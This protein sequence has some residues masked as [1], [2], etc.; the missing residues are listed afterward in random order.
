MPPAYLCSEC[1][2]AGFIPDNDAEQGVDNLL[3]SCVY[4]GAVDEKATYSRNTFDVHDRFGTLMNEG[5][6]SSIQFREY[7]EKKHEVSTARSR[8]ES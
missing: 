7:A 5:G 2:S 6:T 8:G 4:C 1:M 3:V